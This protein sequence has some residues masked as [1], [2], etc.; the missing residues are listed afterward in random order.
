MNSFLRD[1][2]WISYGNEDDYAS[3]MDN[4]SWYEVTYTS[5]FFWAAQLRKI[6]EYLKLRVSNG[7]ILTRT[8]V[9]SIYT[10]RIGCMVIT[11]TGIHKDLQ[12]RAATDS[13]DNLSLMPI[14][15]NILWLDVWTIRNRAM[16]SISQS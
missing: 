1:F 5:L 3:Y 6:L 10:D 2:L 14:K 9:S 11:F 16:N 12:R 7:Y 13:K 4:I 15:R 8:R